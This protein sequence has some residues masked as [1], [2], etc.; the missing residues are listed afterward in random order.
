MEATMEKLSEEVMPITTKEAKPSC[1]QCPQPDSDGEWYRFLVARFD[2]R[3][4]REIVKKER[5]VYDLTEENLK[6]LVLPL[7]PPV[8]ETDA[9]GRKTMNIHMGAGICEEHLAHIPDDKL[10]EPCII[11]PYRVWS[12]REKNDLAMHI[13][14]DG[15]H[16]AVR[17]FREGKAVRA[18]LLTEKEALSVCMNRDP[19]WWKGVRLSKKEKQ[20]WPSPY[21]N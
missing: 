6:V 18:Y 19:T 13:I 8:W 17:L 5:E 12:R 4:A 9:E 3:K 20:P 14:I 11:I 2:V 16:R 15:S 7:K 1:G 21:T 10:D